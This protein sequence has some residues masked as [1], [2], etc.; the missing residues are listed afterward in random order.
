MCGTIGVLCNDNFLKYILDGLYMLQNRGYDSVGISYINKGVHTVKKAS[1]NT[2]NAYQQVCDMINK[3]SPTSQTAIGHTRWATH[4]GKT[5]NNAHPHQDNSEEITLV[6][7]GIID[8]YLELKTMLI[9]KGFHFKTETD[10]EIIAVL[11]SMH[12]QTMAMTLAIE[13]TIQ[14]LSGTWALIIID[15]RQPNRMWITRNG[16]PLLLGYTNSIAMVCSEQSGFNNYITQYVPIDNHRVIEIIRGDGT[17]IINNKPLS[18]KLDVK[19]DT[20]ILTPTPYNYWMEREIFSQSRCVSQAINNGGRLVNDF[21]VKLGGL[22]YHLCELLNAEHL[23][24][25]GCGTSFNAGLWASHMFKSLKVFRTVSV[26]DGAEFMEYDIPN[27]N[28]VFILLSQ[29]GETHDL[30]KCFP[31]LSHYTTIG[32]VNVVDSEIARQT[33]CGVYLN[34]GKEFAVAST[35]SFTNQCVVLSLI[36]VWYAQHKNLCHSERRQIITDI[37]SL[38]THIDD[39]LSLKHSIND[40]VNQMKDYQSCFILGKGSSHAIALEGALKLKEISY[41]HAEGY[42]SSALKHGPFALISSGIP[43]I[44]LDTDDI[45]HESNMNAYNET[46]A[47]EANVITIGFNSDNILSINKNKTFAGVLANIYIQ[48]LS[49]DIALTKDIN[50][51]FPRNLAKVVTVA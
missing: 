36:A 3:K 28:T 47:R 35:K 46:M 25:L 17:M 4:G 34:A 24:I 14:Q 38:S 33:T 49:Y 18:E 9:E 16:S 51:D 19:N 5:D 40:I 2:N 50:P 31:I 41:I 45:Y 1:T 29:S 20:S 32:V 10:T 6:H 26:I 48:M 42:S 23:I 12:R 7:N 37:R 8:N 13:A 44:I 15:P 21:H 27:I 39:V 22:E 11:I 30:I 43:I